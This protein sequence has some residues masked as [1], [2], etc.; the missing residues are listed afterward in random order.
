M[1]SRRGG[2]SADFDL[3]AYLARIGYDGPRRPD[4]PTLSG[5]LAAHMNAIPFENIDVLLGRPIRL[6]LAALQEKIVADR[7]GGYCFEQTALF[8]AALRAP[9]FEATPRTAR[10][11][12]VVGPDEAP[13]GH[14]HVIVRLPEGEYVADPGLGGVGCRAPIPL[15]GTQVRD[16]D[17]HYSIQAD[18]RRRVLRI[19]SAG[20]SFDAWVAGLDEDNW[21]DFEVANHWTATHPASPFVSRLM[22][23]A[24]IP[25]GRI[26]LMNRDV[27]V[28]RDGT[29]DKYRLADRAELR[30]LV[31]T[32]FG[33]DCPE[34][35][36]MRVP[37]EP[38]WA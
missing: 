30:R 11:V 38:G 14:M 17:E 34:L 10:V 12:L 22:L 13:R 5:L 21:V 3:P 24:M 23:R 8:L 25:G 36:T 29:T 19:T 26:T 37:S 15:D 28:R 35:E 32:H 9:G 18:G 27:T 20:R 1:D 31:Q 16:G 33:F 6:D 7:R 4:H 2:R